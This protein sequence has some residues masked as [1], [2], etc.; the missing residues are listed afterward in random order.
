MSMLSNGVTLG[1]LGDDLYNYGEPFF[2]YPSYNS[3][4][5]RPNSTYVGVP[6]NSDDYRQVLINA[7]INP[8][9]GDEEWWRAFAADEA[10]MNARVNQPNDPGTYNTQGA[11]GNND[12]NSPSWWQ[13]ILGSGVIPASIQ[14]ATRQPITAGGSGLI[15]PGYYRAAGGG[16][17]PIPQGYTINP[18][19]GGLQALGAQTGATISDALGT[20]GSFVQRNFIPVIAVVGG[21]LLFKSGRP[22]R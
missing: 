3:D 8:D 16:I 13:R 9:L 22:K 20:F 5:T 17:A 10:A 21:V 4:P 14:A 1:A 15:P 6:Q 2:Y 12:F 7:G 19:T 11:G 18:A